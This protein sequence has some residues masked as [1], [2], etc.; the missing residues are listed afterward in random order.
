MRQKNNQ[1]GSLAGR[2]IG[3]ETFEDRCS[4]F[5]YVPLTIEKAGVVAVTIKHSAS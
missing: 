3:F 5:V 1:S 2:E 4:T